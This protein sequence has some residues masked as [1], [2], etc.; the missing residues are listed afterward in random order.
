MTVNGEY[1]PS[2]TGW[3]REQVETIEETGTTR[4]VHIMNRPVV[5]LTM[6]GA[7]SGLIRKVPLMRVEK[8]GV[9]VVVASKGGS[10]EHP[11]WYANLKANP[12]VLLQDDRETW[13]VRARELADAERA[14]WWPVC[15][16]AYPPYADY[17]VKTDRLIPLLLLERVEQG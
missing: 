1:G 10:P 6:R 5:M 12:D 4:S 7:S 13:P 8:D 15:V 11:Q 2:P 16:E 3:V 17:Q 14:Q 9:Y